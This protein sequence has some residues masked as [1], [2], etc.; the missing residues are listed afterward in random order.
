MPPVTQDEARRWTAQYSLGA[1]FA[2]LLGL[3][4]VY[5]RAA[6]LLFAAA[7]C[8]AVILLL[9]GLPAADY[10]CF[11]ALFSGPPRIRARDPLAS[12]KGEL[13]W[14]VLLH[15]VIWVIGA[16][17][18]LRQGYR[19]LP[20]GGALH[21]TWVHFLAVSLAVLLGLSLFGSPG[22]WLTLFRALQLLVMVLFGL[23]WVQKLG[24]AGALRSLFWGYAAL[25]L[26]IGAAALFRPEL[27]FA[28]ERVRGDYIANAGAV[29]ALGFILLVS[30]PPRLPRWLTALLLGMFVALLIFSL[31][32]SSYIAV[33]LFLLL[34]VI[35]RP[36][37]PAL[38]SMYLAL[39]MLVVMILLFGL[40]PMVTAWIV[41][42]PASLASFSSRIPL[43]R[44]LVPIMLQKAPFFGLGFYAAS[45]VYSLQFNAGIGTAH[46]AFIEVLVGGGILSC[47]L[48]L[49]V[50][51]AAIGR[52][53]GCFVRR[54]KDPQVFVSV[55]LL[56]AV[57]CLGI[58]SEEMVIASP[59]A[60]T[61]WI[62]VSAVLRQPEARSS[63]VA[64]APEV[65]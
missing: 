60:L 35:R 41:R 21:F 53:V 43:W 18:V 4:I 62:V 45:R 39:A 8:L 31:T 46:S 64:D 55:A 25:G 27:V 9:G 50:V 56:L 24:V 65:A 42:D 40:M 59:T 47:G 10:L 34:A 48:F 22:P 37:V 3:G 61:F 1:L 51:G 33:M 49:A 58:V 26:V 57:V 17:W 12:L 52:S 20:R 7:A 14:V 5:C 2:A 13:D 28:G 38:K 15:I 11:L 30:Y 23:L 16:L 32:R 6:T 29:G 36:D 54:G 63:T 44:F 19:L